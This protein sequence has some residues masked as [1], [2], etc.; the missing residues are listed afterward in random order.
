MLVVGFF[1]SFVWVCFAFFFLLRCKCWYII[2]L[3]MIPLCS[4]VSEGTCGLA[5]SVC[6]RAHACLCLCVSVRT[7]LC[8]R[9][10]A[11]LYVQIC[12]FEQ[13]NVCHN[14][15]CIQHSPKTI[16]TETRK[17]MMSLEVCPFYCIQS[18]RNALAISCEH[19][20]NGLPR[21][22][23]LTG[24]RVICDSDSRKGTALFTLAADRYRDKGR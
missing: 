20:T 3:H 17:K 16:S 11:Y 6:P 5:Y 19:Y 22:T 10:L 12:F 8:G 9:T 1:F 2:H 7:Y 21:R 13:I 15:I 4:S 14:H 24:D 18:F 23:T